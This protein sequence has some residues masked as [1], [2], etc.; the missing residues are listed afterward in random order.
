M[1]ALRHH[2]EA[3]STFED[4]DDRA[5]LAA[6]LDLL[7]MAS[8]LGG[9]LLQGTDYC[10]R[11]IGAFRALDDRRALAES[12]ATLALGA[13]TM[14]TDTCVAALDLVEAVREVEQGLVLSQEIGW[15]AGEAFAQFNLA[16]CLGSQGHYGRAL[17]A[18]HASLEIAQEIEHPEWTTAALCVLGLLHRDLLALPTARAYLERSLAQAQ[19]IGSAHWLLLATGMLVSTLAEQ[20]DVRRAEV[21]LN[22]ALD[23]VDAPH[24]SLGQR[25]MWCARAE[26]ALA[27]GDAMEALRSVD[28]LAKAAPNPPLAGPMLRIERLRGEALAGLGRYSEAEAALR[29]ARAYAEADG[30][31]PTIWRIQ[32]ALGRVL[33]AQR[34]RTEAIG[35]F[36]A[37][38]ATVEALAMTLPGDDPLRETF[39]NASATR[40]P[41]ARPESPRRA[42]QRV[43]GGLTPQERQVA[44]LIARACT[45]REIADA[46]VVGERTVETHVENILSKLGLNSRREVVAWAIEHGLLAAAC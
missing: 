22:S 37:A 19:A 46:L 3:L 25:V 45:N 30:A 4:L 24:G 14:F 39:V 13:A 38:R 26:L 28:K 17:A 1:E 18:A 42:A 34:R 43:F 15:R 31:R 9:D 16:F 27:T 21:L 35:A 10:K 20:R 8:Y 12:Q 41:R 29:A 23:P 2:R 36:A 32:V 40:L 33:A 44:A 11:A 6:T 5:A 7:A